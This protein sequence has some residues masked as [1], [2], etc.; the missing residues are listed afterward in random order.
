M[1]GESFELTSGQSD[2]STAQF[3]LQHA[4]PG[5]AIVLTSTT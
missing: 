4:A 3:L 2:R 5:D 1:S